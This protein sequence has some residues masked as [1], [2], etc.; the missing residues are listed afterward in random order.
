MYRVLI[1]QKTIY[2]VE[3]TII[4]LQKMMCH[5]GS[6]DSIEDLVWHPLL[7]LR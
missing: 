1:I 6:L 4:F 3:H 5:R 2:N 7:N